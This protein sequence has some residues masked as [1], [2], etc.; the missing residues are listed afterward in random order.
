MSFIPF[1][2]NLPRAVGRAKPGRPNAETPQAGYAFSLFCALPPGDRTYKRVLDVLVAEGR[3]KPSSI[4]MIEGWGKRWNWQERVKYYDA[5][6]IEEKREV[7]ERDR[8]AA[9]EYVSQTAHDVYEEVAK[10]L[11]ERASAGKLGN[12]AAVQLMKIAA[13]LEYRSRE[14]L[15]GKDRARDQAAAGIQIIIE[16]DPEP[17]VAPHITVNRAPELLTAGGAAE[18]PVVEGEVREDEQWPPR[19]AEDIF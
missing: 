6:K 2:P 7:W 4:R 18:A 1:D 15:A 10:L 11:K 8:V 12:D 17:R 19:E 14:N 5:Q 13:D 3:C 9:H 16:T